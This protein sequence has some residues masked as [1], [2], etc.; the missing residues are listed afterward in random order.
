MLGV[1]TNTVDQLVGLDLRRADFVNSGEERELVLH[2]LSLQH[3]IN[4]FRGNW[5]LKD[6]S[7]TARETQLCK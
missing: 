6:R 2:T 1:V 7:F 5:T 4:F 3:V